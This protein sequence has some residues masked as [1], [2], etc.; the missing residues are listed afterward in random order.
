MKSL[1]TYFAIALISMLCFS[2]CSKKD[3]GT[4]GTPGEIPA[5]NPENNKSTGYS[6][7]DL[8]NDA[9]Y[10]SLQLEVQYM[11]GFQPDGPSLNNMLS[12]LNSILNKPVG[13]TLIQK[14][15]PSSGLKQ[16]DLKEIGAIEQKYRTAYNSNGKIAVYILIADANYSDNG[17]LGVAYRNT[18]FALFGKK[19]NDNSG[20]V[21]QASRT[22]VVTTVLE[23]EFGHLL[24][25]V[26]VGS[27]MKTDHVDTDHAAHC[28]NQDCLMYYATETTELLGILQTG[29]IPSLDNACVAD[30]KANG[31]K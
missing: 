9:G 16:Y 21:G 25:L 6:A 24:G 28:N 31:S 17:V 23:H 4:T 11:P 2:G 18:S 12:L 19:I 8:L 5:I 10:K 7:Y 1:Y 30:L 27:P 22:K 26:D 15:I 3:D 20:G 13:I 14:E 29:K